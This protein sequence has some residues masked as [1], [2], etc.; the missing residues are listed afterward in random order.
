MNKYWE[1]HDRYKRIDMMEDEIIDQLLDSCDQCICEGL[2][3]D[4]LVFSTYN[5]IGED[6]DSAYIERKVLKF[7]C[8]TGEEV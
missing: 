4:Y 8:F 1:T 3:G 5:L 2:E 7:N 6:T